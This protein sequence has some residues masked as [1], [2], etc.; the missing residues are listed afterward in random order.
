MPYCAYC[1]TQIAEVSYKPCP[2]CGNPS[3]GAPRPQV[4]ADGSKTILIIVGVVVGALVIV[5]ILG[6]LAAIAIPNL[7]TAMERSKQKRTMAEMR[8]IAT[9]LEAYAGDKRQYPDAANVA[10]LESALVPVYLKALPKSDG[11]SNEIR[12][13]CWPAG[14]CTSYALASGGKGG[15]FEHETLQE[16]SE[17][18]TTRFDCDIVFA[19]GSFVQYP[20]GV[21]R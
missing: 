18:A 3:N 8:T 15:V 19:N 9:S 12:Y 16:Y 13:A 5:A 17:G 6:I 20:E 11:W 2:A 14:Q 1:G 10:A 7:L 21:Q 4:G